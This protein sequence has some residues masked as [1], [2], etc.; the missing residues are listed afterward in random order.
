MTRRVLNLVRVEVF[1]LSRQPLV[2]VV[3]GL[4]ILVT[5]LTA[6][7]GAPSSLSGFQALARSWQFGTQAAAVSLLILGSL[8]LASE[9]NQG[10]LRTVLTRPIARSELFAAKAVALLLLSLATLAVIAVAG[11]VLVGVQKGFGDVTGVST[12]DK[13]Y[14]YYRFAAMVGYTAEALALSILPLLA[15]GFF[16]LLVS[17]FVENA[18]AAVA[19]AVLLY[20]PL[21]VVAE[22][23]K[24]AAQW[25]SAKLGQDPA[26]GRVV[27]LVRTLARWVL[28]P[29][30]EYP[31]DI[32][33]QL[34]DG[35]T[36][37]RFRGGEVLYCLLVPATYL[38]VSATVGLFHF[39]RKD[40]LV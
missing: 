39:R 7:L 13:G 5:C 34:G 21:G 35:I 1:K 9:T 33:A 18:G 29:Y 31:F 25:I 23:S 37:A 36:T 26:A 14:V 30:L 27:E 12:I 17:A 3:L 2:Y 40:I 19:T 22:L 4:A 15:I 32:L 6:L 24:V 20:L 38:V 8:S 10:T 16:G 28:N 11:I